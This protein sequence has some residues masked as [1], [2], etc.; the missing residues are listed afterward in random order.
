[1]LTG[2]VR[3]KNNAPL[4]KAEISL[5][6]TPYN[7]LA[8]TNATGFFTAFDVCADANQELLIARKGFVPL[9]VKATILTST[10]AN[11]KAT[12]ENAG[13]WWKRVNLLINVL[14]IIV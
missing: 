13:T 7:V 4:S 6:E 5:A 1:M 2:R 12:L 10:T 9:K 14:P 11:V 3:T 8:Q